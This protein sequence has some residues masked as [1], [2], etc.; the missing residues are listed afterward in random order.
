MI[1]ELAQLLS[2]AHRVIDGEMYIDASSGRKIKRWKL[3]D[4]REEDLYKATHVNHPSA[5]WV[6][7]SAEN[8]KWTYDLFVELCKE[9]T[10]RYGKTH[11]TEKKLKVPL[12]RVPHCINKEVGFSQ[13]PQAMPEHCRCDDAVEGYRK[14]YMEEKRHLN[15]WKNQIPE[16]YK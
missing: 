15:S 3:P 6:R 9:F 8:Y 14:Y 12:K 5:I 11:L 7:E 2:T 1:L 16:W 4:N 13:P 10:N